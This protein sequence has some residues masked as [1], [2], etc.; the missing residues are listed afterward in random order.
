LHSPRR[1]HSRRLRR[2]LQRCRSR[3]IRLAPSHRFSLVRRLSRFAS[4]FIRGA[5]D[6][7][8]HDTA[9]SWPAPSLVSCYPSLPLSSSTPRPLAGSSSSL[10]ISVLGSSC[11][12]L[13]YI[14]Y[15]TRTFSPASSCVHTWLIL[16]F[17]AMAFSPAS[18]CLVTL[19]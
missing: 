17:F 2:F 9:S 16:H 4:Y 13:L 1:A 6:Q 10:V 12:R 14:S 18:L 11:Q 7:L 15:T 19:A 3:R 5:A 8:F